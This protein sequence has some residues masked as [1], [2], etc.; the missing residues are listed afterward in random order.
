MH[1]TRIGL[2]ALKGTRHTT[3]QDLDLD[4]GGPRGD[5]VLCLVDADRDRVVRT[6]ENPRMV[7]V[8]A[9]WDGTTLTVATPDGASVTGA[10][11]PTGEVITCDYWSRDADLELLESPHTEL[12]GAHLGR[13]VRL[14]RPVRAGEVVYGACVTLVT[15]GALRGLAEQ[16]DERF[17][18]TFTL[19]ADEDPEP[20]TL[21]RLGS[22]AVVQVR[23]RVPRCRVVDVNPR[24]GRLDT[25]HLRTLARRDHPEGEVPF[26]VDADVVVPGRVVTGDEVRVTSGQP[27]SVV[28]S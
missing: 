28:P 9:T 23:A 4:L 17:R 10:P 26:G 14:A 18:A 22:A 3:L 5:R 7:L 25:T 16:Q 24:T 2:A 27:A 8:T 13:P 11:T 12:I 1:I 21:L 15:T 19:E 20:G 6:V